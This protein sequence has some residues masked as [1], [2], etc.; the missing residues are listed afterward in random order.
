ML[1]ID[2][3]ENLLWR[4]EDILEQAPAEEYCID[5]EN[6][7]FADMQNLTESIREYLK[8]I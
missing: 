1:L 5:S 3:L 6:N 8:E 4:L 7:M 2:K